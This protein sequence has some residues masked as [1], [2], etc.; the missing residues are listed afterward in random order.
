MKYKNIC[1]LGFECRR[2]GRLEHYD[3]W[4]YSSNNFIDIN[5]KVFHK[6]DSYEKA[7]SIHVENT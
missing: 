7:R 3:I 2:S 1:N 4:N 6:K 5:I